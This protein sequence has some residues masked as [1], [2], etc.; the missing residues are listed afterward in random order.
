MKS[1]QKNFRFA[2]GVIELI[3]QLKTKLFTM[4]DTAVVVQ[5]IVFF[6]SKM[7]PPYVEIQKERTKNKLS[8]E[9]KAKARLEYEDEKQKIKE[10]KVITDG[11][12]ICALLGGTI[13][14]DNICHYNNYIQAPGQKVEII[15]VEDHVSYLNQELI[16]VQ[17]QNLA[18][19][20]GPEVKE[21]LL[22]MIENNKQTEEFKAKVEIL[23]KIISN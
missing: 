19:Q 6:H 11:T 8:P 23:G 15:P 2:P 4:S 7:F 3:E 10:S 9:A 20:T 13:E 17:Y 1:I 18:G 16:K 21:K 12:T 5:A 14:G 22:E